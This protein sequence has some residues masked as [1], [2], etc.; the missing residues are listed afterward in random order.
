[1]N[2]NGNTIVIQPATPD[3]VYVPQYD[4]WLVYGDPLAVFPGWYPYPGLFGMV[5][6]SDSDS[7]SGLDSSRLWLG[8]EPLGLRLARRQGLQPQRLHVAQQDDRRSQ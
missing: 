6:G 1:V 4:P 7:A 5:P 3:V 8:M 2:T